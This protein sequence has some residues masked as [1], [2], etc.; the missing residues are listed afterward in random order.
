MSPPAATA[1]VITQ[2]RV[3][4]LL[5][6][7]I[8]ACGLFSE[9]YVRG[10]LIVP[11]DAAATAANIRAAEG[12]FRLGFASDLL[13]F[14][15]DVAVAVLL[16]VL[17]RPVSRPLAL[18]AAALR[19]TGTAIY[20]ANLLNHLAPLLLLGGGAPLQ[21]FSG[22]QL[23]A[24]ALLFLEL[25]GHGYDLGLVFF[26]AHCLALGWLLWRAAL[27]PS[28]LGVLMVL[29]G[30]GYL[31]GS[32]T[33]FLAPAH[34]DAVAPVYLAPLVGELALCLWLLVRGVR[35]PTVPAAEV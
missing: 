13:V 24:M 22:E 35:R 4:G 16:Y 9:L 21:G 20:G 31:V 17:L 2:A 12:L 32:L 33:L 28:V 23:Q 14:L 7:L 1:A 6:L 18:L 11:G 8:I 19:L 25:H 5:Y 30:L 26:G 29:A 10:G 3:T 27:F 34:V 15:A